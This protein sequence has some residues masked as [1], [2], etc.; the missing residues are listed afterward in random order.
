MRHHLG[1]E[2]VV[3]GTRLYGGTSCLV[4]AKRALGVVC[5]AVGLMA[6]TPANAQVFQTLEVDTLCSGALTR[7]TVV[8]ST[9]SDSAT[10]QL[11]DQMPDGIQYFGD[12]SSSCNLRGGPVID[13][14]LLTFPSFNMSGLTSCSV[15][16]DLKAG[17]TCSGAGTNRVSV[18]GL[19]SA[20]ASLACF[21]CATS[22]GSA[23]AAVAS[24]T[25]PF[26]NPGAHRASF[27]ITFAESTAGSPL[28]RTEIRI[29]D[30]RGRLLRVLP[31]SSPFGT[32][33][34][35]WDGRDERGALVPAGIYLAQFGRDLGAQSRR[36]VLVGGR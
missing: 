11:S 22:V 12:L 27:I 36:V 14:Q 20:G 24:I 28:V 31:V 8:I 16:F 1:I 21:S 2:Q 29:V 19:G 33:R 35:S 18:A 17:P 10:V 7:V 34:V 5:V 13:G 4:I 23:A 26:P 15:S 9:A 3:P 32:Q 30:L 6:G 25:G